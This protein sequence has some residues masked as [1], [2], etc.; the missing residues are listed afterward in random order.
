MNEGIWVPR[1]I[2]RRRFLGLAAA[3]AGAAVLG[4]CGAGGGSQGGGGGG[5][6]Y[7]MTLIQG[8]RG[9][10]FYI[11][12]ECGARSKAGELG[13]D[14]N[15][16]GPTEFS[17]AQQTP[18]LNA[19]IQANPDAILIA[20]T[21]KTAMVG[22]IQSAINQDI[23]VFTVDTFIEK[24][25]ALANISS[26]NLEGGRL[27]AEALAK[28]VG[29]EGKVFCISVTPGI[30][31]TDQRQQGFE[32]GLKDYPDIEYLGTEFCDDDPNKAA[33]IANAKIQAEPDL[34]GIFG[35]N[36]FS[37]Q[38]GAAGV[39]QA[40]KNEQVKIVGF[41]AGPTQI[42]DLRSKT[43]DA[44]IA[45]HPADIGTRAV[46][47]AYDYLESGNEPSQKQVKTGLTIVNREN[48]DQPD[49]ERYLYKAE[50]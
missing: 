49:V 14:L 36:L 20:P 35:A 40:G 47:M 38:G 5:G 45:Q 31:T 42:R 48:I 34:A 9:D 3:G 27:A 37:A 11:S 29:E 24:D 30:S 43:V 26:D 18:V 12:M 33:S 10:E 32:E 15:V 2:T 16:Q 25:I 4:G 23:A 22:P 17:P 50:C 6:D 13:V 44:L 8:V 39:R 1:R 28:A 21:D 46:Q 19:A 41:D 7:R